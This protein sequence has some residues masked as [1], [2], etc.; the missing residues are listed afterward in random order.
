MIGK[1]IYAARGEKKKALAELEKALATG[2]RDFSAIDS[3]PY[4]VSLRSD[5]QFQQLI[6]RYR[7]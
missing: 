6:G 7:K 3:S 5:P 4:F 2:Y 1:T